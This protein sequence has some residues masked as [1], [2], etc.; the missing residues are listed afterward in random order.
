MSSSK[1]LSE[2][3]QIQ[4]HRGTKISIKQSL[5]RRSGNVK[6]S[7]K[8]IYGR[9]LNQVSKSKPT[10]TIKFDC[11]KHSIEIK[12]IA[13]ILQIFHQLNLPVKTK[14]FKDL[15]PVNVNDSMLED[16]YP[17]KQKQRLHTQTDKDPEPVLGDYLTPIKPLEL[18]I[19]R[20]DYS[21]ITA[22][23]TETFNYHRFYELFKA[24][25]VHS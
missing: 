3:K 11:N 14:I 7:C 1:N 12:K 23:E 5:D 16:I 13:I 21:T 4:T 24:L 8:L 25:N 19:E 10:V 20:C 2:S 22:K 17:K 18:K 6:N 15:I 9:G